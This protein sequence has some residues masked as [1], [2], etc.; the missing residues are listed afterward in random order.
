MNQ[1]A[2]QAQAHW[3]RF[4]PHRYSQIPDPEQFF[5]TLGQ[6][7]EQEIAELTE[8]LAGDD[9]PGEDFLAKTGRIKAA[10]QQAREAV[11]T[12]RVLLPAEPGTEMDET[13]PADPI[14]LADE[15]TSTS[16][17]TAQET[18]DDD[19]LPRPVRTVWISTVETT[20]ETFWSDNPAES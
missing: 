20:G 19:R 9:L 15:T 18:T 10:T 6:E 3:Q 5:T 16:S 4:L 8:T 7:V 11:L 13:E 2:T 14:T 17:L 12:E 1:Y